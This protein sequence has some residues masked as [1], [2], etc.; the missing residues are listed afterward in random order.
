[1]H[2]VAADQWRVR[3]FLQ[4]VGGAG[5]LAER[6]ALGEAFEDLGFD[7]GMIDADRA[8]DGD[9]ERSERGRAS[10]SARYLRAP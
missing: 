10:A 7:A 2:L 6:R 1:M 5:G 9:R 4:Q 8:G 3:D